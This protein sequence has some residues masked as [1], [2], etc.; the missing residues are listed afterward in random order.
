MPLGC[1]RRML[2]ASRVDGRVVR[3]RRRRRRKVGVALWALW[4]GVW[5]LELMLMCVAMV[6]T[7]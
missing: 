5:A 6:A 7:E 3:V 4:I 1:R 2:S